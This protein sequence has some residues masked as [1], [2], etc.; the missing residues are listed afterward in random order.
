MPTASI[1]RILLKNVRLDIL[2]KSILGMAILGGSV[3]TF[4]LWRFRRQFDWLCTNL[5]VPFVNFEIFRDFFRNFPKSRSK[6]MSQ[7]LFVSLNTL[8]YAA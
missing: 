7:Q 1:A 2:W 4:G 3:F 6:E 5:L 8:I